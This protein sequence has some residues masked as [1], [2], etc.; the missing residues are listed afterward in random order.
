METK[1]FYL[2]TKQNPRAV[3]FIQIV[4]GIICIILAVTWVF[5]NLKSLKNDGTVW[6]TIAF[7]ICFGGYQIL[8]GLGKTDRYLETG[9]GKIILRQNS[10]LPKI[11]LNVN[12]IEKLEIFPLSILFLLKNQKKIIFRFGLSNTEIINPVKDEIIVFSELNVIPCEEKK[13]EL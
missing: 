13:E 9:P 7:L 11:T 10:F 12:D 1:R 5:Y 4:F 6:I 8:A 3:K 2:E